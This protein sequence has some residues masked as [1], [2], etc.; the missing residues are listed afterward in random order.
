M[1]AP[2]GRRALVLGRVV[3][4]KKAPPPPKTAAPPQPRPGQAWVKLFISLGER[5][6]VGPK[7]LV[8][9]ITGEA[10]IDGSQIGKI[11]VK[12]MLSLV[13]VEEPVAEKVIRALNGTT[14]RGRSVR[15]DFDRARRGPVRPARGPG[16]R[17]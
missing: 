8:G 1:V 3:L 9:A 5:D 17:K 15:V 11:E 2:G 13:E 10:G 12:E 14:I 16:R 4:R 6:Q 7:D